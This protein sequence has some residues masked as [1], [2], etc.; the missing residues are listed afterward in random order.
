MPRW[1]PIHLRVEAG[2]L[3]A[4][5]LFGTVR[6]DSEGTTAAAEPPPID[7]D[8]LITAAARILKPLRVRR[9]QLEKL[10]SDAH[11]RGRLLGPRK[12]RG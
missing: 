8:L 6:M 11:T 1:Y 2:R 5:L 7:E 9:S 12:R 4:H 10:I 3:Y